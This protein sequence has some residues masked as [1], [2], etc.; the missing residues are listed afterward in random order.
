MNDQQNAESDARERPTGPITIWLVEDNEPYRISL[1]KVVRPLTGEAAARA[2]A[3][4]EEALE[5]LRTAEP[6]KVILL[7]IGLVGMD[8]IQGVGRFKEVCPASRV[9][10]LTSYDDHDRVVRAICAGASGYLL[11]TSPVDKV[12]E[13]IEEVLAGG[14]PMS[15]QIASA[16]LGLVARWGA[17]KTTETLLSPREREVLQLMCQ[18]LAMKEIGARLG[19]SYHTVDTHIRRVYEKLQVHSRA[20]AVAK[21]MRQGLLG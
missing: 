20:E 16:V 8:G 19:T 17:P 13:A 6:P 1:A 2:F 7:D 15:P 5:A 10:M 11:K 18:G 21:G 14:A 9:I 4:C 3:S 12:R